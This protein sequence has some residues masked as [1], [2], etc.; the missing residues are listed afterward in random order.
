[1]AAASTSRVVCELVAP[2]CAFIARGQPVLHTF[3]GAR[4]ASSSSRSATSPAKSRS[5]RP[6]P[7]PSPNSLTFSEAVRTLRAISPG[8][9]TSAFEL[10]LLPRLAP[11]VNINSLRGRTFLPYDASNTKKKEVILVFAEGELAEQARREGADIVGG[12][13][14]IDEVGTDTG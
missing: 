3:A 10:T 14:L 13:E 2:P 12:S 5:K 1:M 4:F 9:T 6:A 11:S 8:D 7:P